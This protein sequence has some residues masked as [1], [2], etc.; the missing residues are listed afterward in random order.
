MPAPPDSKAGP[1]GGRRRARRSGLLTG[2][3]VS[4]KFSE[5]RPS[6]WPQALLP[7]SGGPGPPW[8]PPAGLGPSDQPGPARA[9]VAAPGPGPRAVRY[10]GHD[11]AFVVTIF[12]KPARASAF[13][14]PARASAVRTLVT[15]LWSRSLA[16]AVT[17]TV[18]AGA[19]CATQTRPPGPH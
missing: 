1:C 17:V 2:I 19:E 7:G 15:I 18:R 13:I 8:H 16:V 3:R 11:T 6:Q 10:F 9:S 4:C 5:S 14:K 12:I